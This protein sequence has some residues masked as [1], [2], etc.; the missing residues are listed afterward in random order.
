M[1]AKP[2]G[3]HD[4]FRN[5]FVIVVK[6]FF[7]QVNVF[8]HGGTTIAHA[9]AGKNQYDTSPLW[10]SALGRRI[11]ELRKA[12]IE[13]YRDLAIRRREHIADVRFSKR[14]IGFPVAV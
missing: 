12:R 13:V 14:Q 3:V 4:T 1:C 8:E 10:T 7:A 2:S 9:H 5:A 6:E 11:R